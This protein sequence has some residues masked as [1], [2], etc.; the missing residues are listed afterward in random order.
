VAVKSASAIDTR[1]AATDLSTEFSLLG[2]GVEVEKFDVLIK[3]NFKPKK[4]I[5]K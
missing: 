3:G 5:F 4:G 2:L 1:W